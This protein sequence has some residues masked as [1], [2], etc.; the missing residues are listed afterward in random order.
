MNMI[1]LQKFFGEDGATAYEWSNIRYLQSAMCDRE[2][3]PDFIQK[4]LPKVLFSIK[5]NW[6]DITAFMNGDVNLLRNKISPEKELELKGS[7]YKLSSRS[8]KDSGLPKFID[9]LDLSRVPGDSMRWYDDLF[10]MRELKQDTYLY[11][12]EWLNDC[13]IS[14]EVRVFIADKRV[15]GITAY[16]YQRQVYSFSDGFMAKVKQEVEEKI[17]EPL[18]KQED[19]A[20]AWNLNEFVIDAYERADGSVQFLEV[21]PYW[22][23]DPCCYGCM[24][25]IGDPL[26]CK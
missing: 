13:D 1:N 21:N 2:K 9:L 18:K 16:N 10:R 3:L 26:F 15:K 24:A 12:L 14:K 7:F 4:L 22:E 11:F 23:S 20:Y 17:L 25:N 19:S 5:I 6:E 8:S